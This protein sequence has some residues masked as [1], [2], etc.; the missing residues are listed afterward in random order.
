MAS[1]EEIEGA[2]ATLAAAYGLA[3]AAGLPPRSAELFGVAIVCDFRTNIV[4][5][6][7]HTEQG[8]E[9][10][11]R[12]DSLALKQLA[13]DIP[14]D[15]PSF[16]RRVSEWSEPIKAIASQFAL[17]QAWRMR[18]RAKDEKALSAILI[19]TVLSP[20]GKK[21][22]GS[23]TA[24]ETTCDD[25]GAVVKCDRGLVVPVFVAP[26]VHVPLAIKAPAAGIDEVG[27]AKQIGIDMGALDKCASEL[28]TD[29]FAGSA[30]AKAPND[31]TRPQAP[32][33]ELP[34]TL[35]VPASP[36]GGEVPG[37]GALRWINADAGTLRELVA[38][39]LL[40]QIVVEVEEPLRNVEYFNPTTLARMLGWTMQQPLYRSLLMK[41]DC[42]FYAFE[43]VEGRTLLHR[44]IEKSAPAL[45][46]TMGGRRTS[47]E[48]IGFELDDVEARTLSRPLASAI[49]SCE[50]ICQR[51]L[52]FGNRLQEGLGDTF[53]PAWTEAIGEPSRE[54]VHNMRLM[55]FLAL[56]YPKHL[57]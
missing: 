5:R 4:P 25:D 19:E 31:E 6:V 18:T 22:K 9:S 26:G 32:I 46:M 14:Y 51:R 20:F 38:N 37:T 17:A 57:S 39:G 13:D 8:A 11:C 35:L 56:A 54:W 42:L 48:L 43:R 7:A 47:F 33:Q 3:R 28:V 23:N 1:D 16:E 41:A 53:T 15:R 21:A 24:R 40:D 2:K 44:T 45:M 50:L 55:E 30:D 27:F 36:V 52:V 34:R 49:A 29:P 10:T 12:P